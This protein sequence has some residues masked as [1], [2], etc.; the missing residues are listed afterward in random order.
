VPPQRVFIKSEAP[1]MLAGA[2]TDMEKIALRLFLEVARMIVSIVR[3][4]SQLSEDAVQAM[5]PRRG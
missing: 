1:S 4:R 5:A 2:R 3:F